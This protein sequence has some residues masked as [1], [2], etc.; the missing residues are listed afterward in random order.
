MQNLDLSRIL[1][2]VITLN[3]SGRGCQEG[4]RCW[5]ELPACEEMGSKPIAISVLIRPR[6]TVACE[7]Q[8]FWK[9]FVLRF[10]SCWSLFHLFLCTLFGVPCP[11]NFRFDFFNWRH[12]LCKNISKNFLGDWKVN[13]S[14]PVPIHCE[15]QSPAQ[16][17][18]TRIFPGKQNL[19]TDH[20]IRRMGS[21][22]L[23]SGR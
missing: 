19:Y 5:C 23:V 6:S 20:K 2:S 4:N 7:L 18:H 9:L 15:H 22:H 21:Q 11:C 13:V 1:T 12:F 17:P 8:T 3:L 16:W 14:K 10:G